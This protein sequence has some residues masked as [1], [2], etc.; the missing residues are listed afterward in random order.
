[1]RKRII[2]IIAVLMILALIGTSTVFAAEPAA[3]TVPSDV[4]GTT[5]EEAVK[6]LVEKEII[7]GDADGMF[8]PDSN[9]TRAQACVIVV[10]SMNPAAAEVT[11]TAT[12]LVGKSGFADMSGYGWAEGY[13]KYAVQ[14]GVTK[15]YPDGTFK[16][17]NKVTMNELITMILRAA[18]YTDE[19]L[20]GAW[21]SNYVSKAAELDL[22]INIPAPLPTYATKWMA[23]QLDYNAL[24][25]IEAAK[26]P[27]PRLDT[28]Q[29]MPDAIPN[30]KAMTFATGSFNS[31]MKTYDG[32][33]IS[34]DVTVYTYG[35]KKNYSSTMTFPNKISDYRIDTVYRYK[36][37]K[38]PAFYQLENGKIKTMV[39]PMDAGFSGRAHSVINKTV[40]TINCKDE[41]VTGIS[42]LTA[43]KEI[44]WL[45][46]KGLT[47][48]PAE[49]DYLKG[50]IYQLNLSDGEI[51][52][53][54]KASETGKKGVFEEISSSSEAFVDVESFSDS[55][56]KITTSHGGAMFKIK[57]NATVY[58]LDQGNPTE[59]KTGRLSA[60]KPGVKIRAYDISDDAELSADMI[61]I[62]K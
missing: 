14:H 11:G 15:G 54:Y 25:K 2:R 44:T 30:V 23:A 34:N 43:T 12:Q 5:Y 39:V 6:A 50:E 16:P 57:D 53:I 51:Q 35:E 21:P 27:V 20:G 37:T 10:K 59:Y 46:K 28:D 33:S 48:I 56:A 29:N 19:T 26:P 62:F 60:I 31:D 9:L 36:N 58:V 17:G 1:M 8:H 45:G 18:D 38:T 4:K 3:V 42:T 40:S 52:S 49:T 41:P 61:V 24:S 13:I 22:M 7:T 32:K 47:G 55:V